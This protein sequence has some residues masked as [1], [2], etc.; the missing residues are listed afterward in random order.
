MPVDAGF[1][2][3]WK[4]HPAPQANTVAQFWAKTGWQPS[5]LD[6]KTVLDAGCGCGRFSA[7]AASAGARVWGID[8]SEHAIVAATKNSRGSFRVGNLLA[9][10]ILPGPMDMAFSLGVLHH[11][12]NP[13]VA[14]RN[15]ANAVKRGGQLAVWL[16]CPPEPAVA[17]HMEFL[18]DITRACPP[19]ALHAACERHAVKLRDLNRGAC[20]PLEQ[21]LR[22]STSADDDEC[23]S[24][25]FDWHTPQFRSY[26]T[27][28][29][30]ARWFREEGFSVDW[31]GDFPT[32]MRGTRK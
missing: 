16:Y 10:L 23:V 28:D 24:D 8:G 31:I 4:A 21:V 32:S 3:R 12:A 17:A 19:A 15:V 29:E 6:G 30:L 20:G 25:T 7:V 18:H 14:F 9:P 11:T 1:D 22:V 26:H 27:N 2:Y 13:R 5:D